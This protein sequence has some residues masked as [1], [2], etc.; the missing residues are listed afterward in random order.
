M[1]V[2]GRACWLQLKLLLNDSQSEISLKD[3]AAR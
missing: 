1:D 2:Q 3:K